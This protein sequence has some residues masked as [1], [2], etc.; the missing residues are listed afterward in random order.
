MTDI[1]TVKDTNCSYG[2]TQVIWNVSFRVEN[3]EVCSIIGA[4]G[5]GKTTLLKALSGLL[6]PV[7]GSIVFD[8][9]SIEKALPHDIVKMGLVQIPEGGG[10]FPHMTVLENL[11]VGSYLIDGKEAEKNLALVFELFPILNERKRQ[12]ANTLSGGERQMLGIGK[13]LT[14]SPRLLLL[15]EPSLGL[16]PKMVLKVFSTI[17]EINEKGVPILLVEQNVHHALEM[18]KRAYVL[19]NG[20][21]TREGFSGDLLQDDYVRK[22]YLGA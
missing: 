13:G 14:A 5:A 22:A 11:R 2:H 3:Q 6:Q 20:S 17:Q 21:I 9:T 18:A 12:L 16:S 7:S 4:N 8:G 15:D 10:V 1:L 19:E